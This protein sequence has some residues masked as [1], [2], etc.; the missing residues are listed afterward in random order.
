MQHAGVLPLFILLVKRPHSPPS[1]LSSVES[2][3]TPP[4]LCSQNT[5]GSQV[6]CLTGVLSSYGTHRVSSVPPRET[7]PSYPYG[8]PLDMAECLPHACQDEVCR[9]VTFDT[10]FV[11]V[12]EYPGRDSDTAFLV[13]LVV[14]HDKPERTCPERVAGFK[15]RD[16]H[17]DWRVVREV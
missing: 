16:L 6:K 1:T 8:C 17:L 11:S 2:S 10:V 15:P 9:S 5:S 14:Q 3:V 4:G 12:P 7:A 13:P